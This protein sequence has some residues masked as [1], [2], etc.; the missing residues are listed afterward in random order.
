MFPDFEF[1]EK[2]TSSRKHNHEY[3]CDNGNHWVICTC[4]Y[5]RET[6]GFDLGM[7]IRQVDR[8]REVI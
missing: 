7:S 5:A 8:L 3:L 4:D 1:R 6:R 2:V